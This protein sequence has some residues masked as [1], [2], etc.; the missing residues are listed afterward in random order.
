M[1]KKIAITGG[2]KRKFVID[3]DKVDKD[4]LF[5]CLHRLDYELTQDSNDCSK[6][7]VSW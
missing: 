5:A 4:E 3:F 6:L 1:K 2:N 7:I